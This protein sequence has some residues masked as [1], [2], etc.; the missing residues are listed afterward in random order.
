MVDLCGYWNECF[1]AGTSTYCNKAGEGCERKRYLDN[2]LSKALS[3]GDKTVGD[4]A[5]NSCA[6]CIGTSSPS[7]HGEEC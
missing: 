6:S 1:L 4:G 3:G 2:F 5:G 7:V